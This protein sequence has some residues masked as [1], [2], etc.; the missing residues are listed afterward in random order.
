MWKQIGKRIGQY[1]EALIAAPCVAG[2]VIIANSFGC[3][4]L[5]EWATLDKFFRLR[6]REPVDP[7]IVVVT[8]D[9][10]DIKRL[11]QWP[12][13]DAVLAKL[14]ENLKKQQPLAIG[15][16]LY[17]NLPVQPGHNALV[18]VYQTTPNL[19]AVEKV[20]GETVTPPVILKRQ[21]QVALA[22]LVIDADGKVRRGLL[23]VKPNENESSQLSLAAR[24]AL[25]YLKEKGIGLEMADAGKKHL[26]LGKALFVPL[27]GNE[28]GYAKADA[29]GYQILLNY[30]G[31]RE[32]FETLSLKDALQNRIQPNRLR[33][34][35]V[36][37]GA[38][39]QSFNDLF[40]TPYGN[41]F[42]GNPTRTPGVFIHANLTSQILSA[43]L[44]GRRLIRFWPDTVEWLWFVVWSFAGAAGCW[45][46]LQQNALGKKVFPIWNIGAVIGAVASPIG[47]SYLVFLNGWWIPVVAPIVA[48]ITSAIVMAGYY[49]HKLHRLASLDGLTQIANRRYF[50]EYI[51][52]QWLQSAQEK[53]E[54]S[55]ILC[56][57]D[58]FKT[59]N[60]T[61][62]H[63][64][65]D[66]CLQQVA[67]AIG[68]AVRPTDLIARYG[69]EEFVVILLDTNAEVAWQV[70]QK[71][72]FQ[73]KALQIA[74]INS[75][76][77]EYVT[78]SCGL[79]S[80]IA[81][82]EGLPV[83]LIKMADEALYEAKKMGRDRVSRRELKTL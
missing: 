68:D 43:A 36:L 32:N 47:A 27:K 54:L 79:A 8:I 25:I 72:C 48:L 20:V 52:K 76:V 4:Q 28:G 77:S 74:H 78:L 37:I 73:V 29:G 63:Q 64:S 10:S 46:W 57:V 49:N 80:T 2:L 42:T 67:K 12:M 65:G 18:K 66:W 71:I 60:D 26:K 62:G 39:G 17:R 5:L 82:F 16:D 23:S 34:R 51:E 61:Y 24:L 38:T 13:S 6:P 33:D 11:G 14:I 15:M 31:T 69:G 70:A 41:S 83:E 3:F 45:G 59:Y 44:E 21:N 9:E 81:D 35:I 19:I 50:N 30:R 58:Y 53:R 55:I 7:R 75:Q 56:D 40:F 1:K 22:D